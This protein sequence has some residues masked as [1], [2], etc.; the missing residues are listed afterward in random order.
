MTRQGRTLF[1]VAVVS[2]GAVAALGI[3]AD[4]YGRILENRGKGTRAARSPS[5]S[6]SRPDPRERGPDWEMYAFLDARS[7]IRKAIEGWFGP[8]PPRASRAPVPQKDIPG[9]GPLA[10]ALAE[11][12]RFRDAVL[13]E[14]GLAAD[15]YAL[16]RAAYRD[17]IEG[18]PVEDLALASGIERLASEMRSGDL[19]GWEA[20]DR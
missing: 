20:A 13:E 2:I 4:R 12:R 6:V 18:K 14:R 17:W 1:F 7:E 15:R 8:I 16:I 9:E 3:M 5:G 19:S 10:D 11:A